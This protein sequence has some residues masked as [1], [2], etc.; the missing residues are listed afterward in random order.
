MKT[1]SSIWAPSGIHRGSIMQSRTRMGAEMPTLTSR[2]AITGTI[3]QRRAGTTQQVLVHQTSE[4]L[5]RPY[6][7]LLDKL[8]VGEPKSQE[9]V[10]SLHFDREHSIELVIKLWQCKRLPHVSDERRQCTSWQ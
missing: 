1:R 5:T 4:A 8:R 3:Q 9:L 6:Q 10:I 2:A 7:T